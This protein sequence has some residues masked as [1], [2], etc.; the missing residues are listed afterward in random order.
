LTRRIKEPRFESL[1]WQIGD[2]LG[3]WLCHQSAD[4][5]AYDAI[6]PIPQHWVRRISVRY[7]H[8]EVL[9]ER[10][11]RI[12][13]LPVKSNWLFRTRW[14]KKQGTMSIVERLV[15]VENSFGCR[16]DPRLRKKRLL[17]VDDVMTSGATLHHAAYSLR[18]AGAGE[19]HVLTFARGVGAFKKNSAETKRILSESVDD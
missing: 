1:A 13:D 15:N 17:L 18:A 5:K 4:S 16:A 2:I 6:V 9:A 3:D 19:I 7:N 12:M 14:T 11:G 8:S 10:V